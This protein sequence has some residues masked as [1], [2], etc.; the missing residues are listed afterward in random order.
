MVDA[1][2]YHRI[3]DPFLMACVRSVWLICA[4]NN[5][6][7]QVDHVRGKENIYADI[8]SRRQAYLHSDSPYVSILKRCNWYNSQPVNA[9]PNFNI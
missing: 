6:K 1:Y 4:V 9:I 8:L 7:L 5:I 2:T 3:Q